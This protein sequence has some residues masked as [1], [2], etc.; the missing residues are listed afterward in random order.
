MYK[1]SIL[2]FIQIFTR[3][4]IFE[5]LRKW[6]STK[7]TREKF[8]AKINTRQKLGIVN[9]IALATYFRE[10]SMAIV[11]SEYWM[12]ALRNCTVEGNKV[13]TPMRKL[14]KKLPGKKLFPFLKA[15]CNMYGGSK[16]HEIALIIYI[17]IAPLSF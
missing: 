15:Y 17:F 14:I 9:T 10:A 16:Q 6:F 8:C 3:V 5:P 1:I 7:I 12:S 11:D 2:F 4:L 13:T